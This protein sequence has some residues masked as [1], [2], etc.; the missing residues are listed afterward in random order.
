MN[1]SYVV[2]AD[3]GSHL[4]MTSLI[5]IQTLLALSYMY[6]LNNKDVVNS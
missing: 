2:H 1:L 4:E 3:L 6:A 5:F